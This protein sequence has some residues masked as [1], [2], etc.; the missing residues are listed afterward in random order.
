MSSFEMAT[1]T[2]STLSPP[3]SRAPF[4][5]SRVLDI[6]VS[7][8]ALLFI[9]PLLLTLAIMIRLQDGGPALFGQSRIGLGGKMFTCFKLRS[10]V[11]DSDARLEALLSSDPVARMEWELDHKLRED[12]RITRLGGFLRRSSLDEL[13]QLFNVL[14]GEMSLVGPRPIVPKERVK[15]G[16]KFAA[17]CSVTPGITGLWQV[18]GRN[19]VSY[20]R[21]VAMDVIYSRSKSLSYDLTIIFKTIPAVL[22]RRGSY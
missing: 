3:R 21:R 20:R 9:S 7:L 14:R 17:Y 12:P 8:A 2:N 1:T 22:T 5:P 10:M 19:N 11:M 6:V 15:Y 16:S 13:P 18:S 4:S